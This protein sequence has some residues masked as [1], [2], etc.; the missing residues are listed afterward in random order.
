MVLVLVAG[1]FG[2]ITLPT[3]V[4]LAIL[5]PAYGAVLRRRVTGDR[6]PSPRGVVAI[7]AT[8]L[9]VTLFWQTERLARLGGEAEAQDIKDRMSEKLETVTVFS[10]K[11][12][13]IAAPGVT[14]TDF[15]D[16]DAAYR[17][18]YDGFYLLQRS[19]NKYFLVTDGWN[20][21]KGR[22]IVAPDNDS[23]RLEFGP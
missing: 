9:I 21:G 22:L 11:N 15:G 8:L 14:T 7:L 13:H 18:R 17:F 12:L 23:I 16:S 3:W 4:A 2:Y 5:G 6:R 20:D 1:E 10:A 19:G